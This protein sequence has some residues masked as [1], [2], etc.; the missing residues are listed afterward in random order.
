MNISVIG[1]GYVG[2]PLAIELS[3][4]YK[5]KG[6][7]HDINRIDELNLGKDKNLQYKT[8]Q[9]KKL[10]NLNFT[11]N[12]LDLSNSKIFIITVPTPINKNKKPDLT[13]IKNASN[14]ISHVIK[15]NDIIILES[16]VYPGVTRNIVGKIIE[17][18]LVLNCIKIFI[19][20]IARRINPGDKKNNLINIRKIIGA[21]DKK[22]LSKVSKIYDSFLQKK[23]YQTD[24]IEIAE[25]A[26]VIENTQRDINIALINEFNKIFNNM[27][28]DTNKILDA[29]STKWNFLNF[30]PGLVGG[31]CIGIDPHLAYS[32][33][34]F[35]VKPNLILSGRKINRSSKTYNK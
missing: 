25:A 24:S 9:L 18:N 14:L 3:K 29:A 31:H 1:L 20:L 33:R 8:N 22:T 4:N 27:N 23:I 15:K 26:K 32:A 11:N 5:V 16:T 17:K 12:Y 19:W 35:G 13:L 21:S 10:K 30:K 28:L 2:L 34:S 6:Y 7:D